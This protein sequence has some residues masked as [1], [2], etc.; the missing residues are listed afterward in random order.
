[1]TFKGFIYK[2]RLDRFSC[3]LF[4]ARSGTKGLYTLLVDERSICVELNK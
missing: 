4:C 1:M 2:D 3:N